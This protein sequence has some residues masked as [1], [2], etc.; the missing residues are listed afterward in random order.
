M[1]ADLLP[2]ELLQ[3]A[4]VPHEEGYDVRIVDAMIEPDYMRKLEELCDGALLFASSCILG[5][6]VVHGARVAKRIRERFPDLP[7]IWGGWFPSVVPELYLNEGIADAVGLGQGE[8]T[9]ADVVRAIDAG[10]PLREVPGLVVKDGDDIV[11]TDHRPVVGFD[12]IPKV[13]WDLLDFEKYVHL[14]HNPGRAKIRHKL[15]DPVGLPPG[16]QLRTFSYFSSFGCPEPCTFCCSPMVTGRRWKAI[17]G[18]ELADDLFAL[19]DRFKFNHVRFQDANFGVAEK[20]SNAFCDAL[21]EA[22]SPFWWNATYEVETIARYKEESCD[23]LRDS[24]CHLVIL[25]AEAGSKE[26]QEKIKKKID[27]DTNLE[28]ALGRIFDRG[29]QTGT[30][31]IIG[32]P[33]ESKE[34]MYATIDMAAKMKHKFPGSA[35][36]IF[37]FRPI[38]GTEDFDTA[39]K[40]GYDAPKSFEDWGG[41]LEYKYETDD[42]SL[43]EE[44]ELRWRRYGS[45]ATFYDGLARQGSGWMLKALK[46]VASWRL[47][48]G[49]YRFPIEQKLFDMY[50]RATG[51]TESRAVEVDRTSGVTPNPA[52]V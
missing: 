13:P 40:L 19:Q 21:I 49:E 8:L 14:Q 33:G 22:G 9:F 29:I 52:Q 42:I 6:Q 28:L 38:P 16:T 3:I 34:S 2:L 51:Q 18:D 32:Y 36:D 7:M 25:G 39:V 30:T 24:K 20:R 5:F 41:C 47:E 11:Y 10:T 17:A 26:Q 43:P 15:P 1:A 12:K 45:T 46:R 35:S 31:W 27:L 37:P 4:G 50:V 48:R 23:R 44:I